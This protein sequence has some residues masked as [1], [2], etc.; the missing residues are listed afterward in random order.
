ML[1]K[2]AIQY[3]ILLKSKRRRL[4]ELYKVEYDPSKDK[5]AKLT[6]KADEDRQF[7]AQHWG[8]SITGDYIEVHFVSPEDA[9]KIRQND[10]PAQGKYIRTLP[11]GKPGAD[12]YYLNNR[13]YVVSDGEANP[14]LITDAYVE[15][16]PVQSA[17]QPS[18]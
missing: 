16:E 8:F 17:T 14:T 2:L 12:M 3:T 1:A 10:M 15:E 11:P 7:K 6:Y 9:E 13:S 18:V 4:M 5:L